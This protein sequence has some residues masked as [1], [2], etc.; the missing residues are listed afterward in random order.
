MKS[1]ILSRF[2]RC[3]LEMAEAA[4]PGI[5]EE[6]FRE[7]V[8]GIVIETSKALMD[9]FGIRRCFKCA[10]RIGLV[11]V[12]GVLVCAVHNL[13]EKKGGDENG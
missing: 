9:Q 8:S 6:R 3:L 11:R 13:D 12:K 1:E 2:A 10:Q 4:D 5:V 7:K